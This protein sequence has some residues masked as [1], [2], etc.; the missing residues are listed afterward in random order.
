MVLRSLRNAQDRCQR[1]FR[2]LWAAMDLQPT[3]AR[4]FVR[5]GYEEEEIDA[6]RIPRNGRCGPTGSSRTPEELVVPRPQP[7]ASGIL[8]L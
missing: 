3:S 1:F 5:R 6:R 4:A 7:H 8:A 2:K